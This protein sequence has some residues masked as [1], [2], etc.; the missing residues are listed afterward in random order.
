M[1]AVTKRNQT[2]GDEFDIKPD[3]ADR[4]VKNIII[5]MPRF[6][7]SP[8]LFPWMKRD[9]KEKRFADVAEVKTKTTVSQRMNL[10]NAE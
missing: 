2:N 4:T 9:M 3:F 10:I 1:R 7:Y 6:P 5:V 8:D